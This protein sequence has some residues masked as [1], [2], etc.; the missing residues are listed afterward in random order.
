MNNPSMFASMT[1]A[2]QAYALERV[3]ARSRERLLDGILLALELQAAILENRSLELLGEV[4][5]LNEQ[6]Q[7]IARVLKQRV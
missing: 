2:T 1:G 4:A 7:H 3:A 6:V 5:E